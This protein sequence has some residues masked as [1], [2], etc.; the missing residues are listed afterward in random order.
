MNVESVPRAIT[1]AM[2]KEIAE[3]SSVLERLLESLRGDDLAD[4]DLG[5]DLSAINHT[6]EA[7]GTSWHAALLGKRFLE[8]MAR[9]HVEVDISSEYRYR[10][11]VAS[12][13]T[14]VVAISQSGET[15]DTLASL[16]LAKSKSIPVIS[17]V[18]VM[19]STIA[20]ESDG[21]MPL[22]AGPEIGVASTK[23]YTAQVFA[24]YTFA[25]HMARVKKRFDNAPIRE[26]LSDLV[27]FHI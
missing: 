12:G 27:G 25:L 6:L 3:Q 4:P 24:L 20:R 8:S 16:R 10:N 18:N 11:P 1:T 26:R 9:I 21:V 23:A 15:A 13:G 19:D 2:S 22:M 7:A 5:I 14:L 17:L